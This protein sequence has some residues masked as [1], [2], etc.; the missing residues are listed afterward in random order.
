MSTSIT[1]AQLSLVAPYKVILTLDK[2]E[3]MGKYS[4]LVEKISTVSDVRVLPMKR[5]GDL[6]EALCRGGKRAVDYQ[7]KGYKVLLWG[8]FN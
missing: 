6:N 8:R 7:F 2:G 3:A 1:D 4:R 5:Y